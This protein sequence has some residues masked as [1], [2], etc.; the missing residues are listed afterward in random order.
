MKNKTLFLGIALLLSNLVNSQISTNIKPDS[1]KVLMKDAFMKAMEEIDTVKVGFFSKSKPKVRIFSKAQ[2]DKTMDE[3]DI[4]QLETNLLNNNAKILDSIKNR[5]VYDSVAVNKIINALMLKK[6]KSIDSLIKVTTE[7]Y[8]KLKLSSTDFQNQITLLFKKKE[9]FIRVKEEDLKN[10]FA[11]I[12]TELIDAIKKNDKDLWDIEEIDIDVYDG[13]IA[14]LIVTLTHKNSK[15]IKRFTNKVSISV[16]R[17]SKYG[18]HRLYETNGSGNFVRV[19]DV[20]SYTSKTGVNYFP[21]NALVNI[22]KEETTKPLQIKRGLKSILDFRVYTDLL[23]LVDEESNGI[24]NFEASSTIK[25]SPSPVAMAWTEFLFFKEIK[26]YFNYS[27]F[28]K[29]NRAIETTFNTTLSKYEISNNLN[30]IQNAFIS[31]GIELNL[32]QL[33]LQKEFP[34]SLSF[35]LVYE[36]NMTEVLLGT[37]K[38]KVNS[39]RTS[40]GVSANFR[41]TKNFGLNIGFFYS[42]V[43]NKYGSEYL[44]QS[45]E[46][47]LYELNSELYFYNPKDVNSAFFLRLN[48]RRI[49]DREINY[50]SIQFG[51]KKAFSFSK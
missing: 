8:N 20:L 32:I 7:N 44:I 12:D 19:K 33:K 14:D 10:Y 37:E 46:F 43:D 49:T 26:P 35:P 3:L 5:R 41:R 9:E 29:E 23:G 39:Y 40:L 28:D 31:T 22:G 45:P 18:H 6:V 48:T 30:L 17:F 24:I 51:Y 16:L 38:V 2:K 13:L 36:F 1:L 27:R 34:F 50:A 21:D 4:I 15:S 47:N 11:T 42:K 25:I